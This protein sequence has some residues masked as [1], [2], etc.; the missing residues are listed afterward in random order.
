MFKLWVKSFVKEE[1][2]IAHHEHSCRTLLHFFRGIR[3]KQELT[4]MS[5]GSG[6]RSLLTQTKIKCR[7]LASLYI[8]ELAIFTGFLRFS[9][10]SHERTIAQSTEY[11][12]S[13]TLLT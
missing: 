2:F 12:H 7:K 8:K 4:E 10:G 1:N 9:E 13:G 6:K 11:K 3:V 5:L